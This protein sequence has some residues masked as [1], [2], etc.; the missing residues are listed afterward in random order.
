LAGYA[1]RY[2]T[3]QAFL[4]ELALVQGVSAENV[5]GGPAKDDKLVLSTIHQAKGLEWPVCFV[6][7]LA[8]GRFPSAQAVRT[9]AE[10][11]EE[12]RLFYVAATRAADELYLCYPTVED[13]KNGPSRLI[14]PSRF[15]LE[16]DRPPAVFDR[17]Q[18]SEEPV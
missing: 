11:E 17:W 16:L 8:D 3:A 14:R 1:E 5:L 13:G 6:L 12:R 4:S 2:P 18:I 9:T 10:V 7:W 15:L